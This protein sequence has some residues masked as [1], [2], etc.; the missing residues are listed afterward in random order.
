[1]LPL[2]DENPTSRRAWLTLALI[3]VNVAVFVVVQPRADTSDGI[4]FS[5]EYAA[6]PC[7]IVRGSPLTVDEIVETVNGDDEACRREIA[8][9]DTPNGT[10]RPSIHDE[11]FP[12]KN[13]WLAIVASMFLHGGWLHLGFNMWFLW[14]FGNNV[15][16]HLGRTRYLL[17][18]LAGGVIATFAHVA[19]GPNSTVPIIG[20][21]GAVAAVMGA[22]LV[23]FPNARVR[24]LVLFF[25]VLFVQVRAKWLLLAWLVSQF[26]LNTDSGIA[27]MAH[28]GG[29]VFGSLV[30]LAIRES[31]RARTAMW[32]NDYSGDDYGFWNNRHGGRVD[33]PTPPYGNELPPYEGPIR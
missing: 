14:I 21:S 25:L 29:F 16:D 32:R 2:H 1:V 5:Y 19:I 11:V 31:V 3:A 30:G 12:E 13:P 8:D 24:T 26:F 23:W 6:I 28:V 20:A 18:Y 27:W 15:E 33:D 22:Y 10:P 7:E 9:S 17:F 4:E